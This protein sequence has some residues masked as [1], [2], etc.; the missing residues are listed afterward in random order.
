MDTSYQYKFFGYDVKI[1]W[2]ALITMPR[3]DKSVGDPLKLFDVK[4]SM[5]YLFINSYMYPFIHSFNNLFIHLLP[6]CWAYD[7]GLSVS[8]PLPIV[9]RIFVLLWFQSF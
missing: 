7:L 8:V 6:P 1:Y 9:M 3:L 5:H 4:K 2:C